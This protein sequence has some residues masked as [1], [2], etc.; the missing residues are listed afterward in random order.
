MK[1]DIFFYACSSCGLFLTLFSIFY[2]F[3]FTPSE[4]TIGEVQKIFY[5]HVASAM[6]IYLALLISF[7][8]AFIFT[9]KGVTNYDLLSWSGVEVATFW[10]LIV[11]ITGSLWA[12]ETWGVYWVWEPRLT[13]VAILF[14]LF[15]LYLLFRWSSRESKKGSDIGSLLVILMSINAI[16]VHIAVRVWGGVHSTVIYKRGGLSQEML[17]PFIISI[18]SFCLITLV[19]V[20]IRFEIKRLKKMI[21]DIE[22]ERLVEGEKK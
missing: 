20:W 21:E 22:I 13:S 8:S 5:F 4:A 16:F 12:K 18:L 10:C 3:F 19:A 15:S 14:F 2:I 17:F 7:I 9:I 6:N 1:R 11:I